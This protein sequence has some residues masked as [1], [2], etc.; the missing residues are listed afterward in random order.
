MTDRSALPN[1]IIEALRA[2]DAWLRSDRTPYTLIGGVAVSL[3]AEPR[4]TKDIDAVV[5]LE[6]ER[7]PEFVASGAAYDFFPRIPD[8]LAFAGLH[9]VLLLEYQSGHVDI[10]ISFGALPFEAEMIDGAIERDT[11]DLKIRVARPEDLVIMKAVAMRPK[12]MLDILS[13]LDLNPD[14]DRDRIRH[15]V[16][17]FAAV[18]EMPEMLQSLENALQRPKS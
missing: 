2:L 11:M 12:D 8:A 5:W 16:A 4:V 3:I 1:P 7:W 14:I 9:R 13:I 17:Q 15:W 10:D 6:P 18:L